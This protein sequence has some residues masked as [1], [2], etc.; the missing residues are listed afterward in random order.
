VVLTSSKLRVFVELKTR[1][2]VRQVI[3]QALAQLMEYAYWPDAARCQALL[4]VGPV[5]ASDHEQAYLSTLRNRFGIPV[6][7]LDYDDGHISGI[8]EWFAQ[9]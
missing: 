2:T 6:H 1:G 7:Y 5:E 4:I 9:L 3:R 8:R